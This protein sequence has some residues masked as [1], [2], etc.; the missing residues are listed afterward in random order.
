MNRFAS[1]VLV[2]GAGPSGLS[3]LRAF[4]LAE[5][6][7]SVQIPK[8]KCYEKQ[9]DWGG[10]WNYTWRTGLDQYGEPV[11]GSMYK[12]LWSNAPKECLEFADYSCAQHFE[13]KPMPSYL[14][15]KY[16]R[17]YIVGRAEKSDIRRLIQFNSAVKFVEFTNNVFNVR[18]LDLLTGKSRLEQYDYVIVA[19]SHFSVPNVPHFEGIDSFPGRVIHSHD[20]RDAT[21]FAG[22]KI[23][24]VGA[25]LSAEDVALQTYKF[26]AKSITISYRTKAFGFKWPESIE[27]L[28]LLTRIEGKTVTFS[29]GRQRDFDSIILCT[30]YQHHFPFLADDLRLATRNRMY[31][32]HLYKGIFFQNQPRLMFLGM[33]KFYYILPYFDSQAYYARDVILGR[34]ALPGTEDRLSDMKSWQTRE[35]EIRHPEDGID[36]QAAYAADLL[37]VTDYSKVDLEARTAMFKLGQQHKRDCIVSYR[38]QGFTSTCTGTKAT[39]HHTLWINNKQE[40]LN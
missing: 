13:N 31:P 17:D 3:Q 16:F 34:I 12:H 14:P 5:S 37:A 21:H 27:E 35:E 30:G 4:A 26:G 2:I 18:V 39:T 7:A 6:A 33:Q 23:L 36:F 10:M 38:D 29:D 8:V 24:I 20:L 25:G 15:R 1:R 32:D 28:P 11:H 19:V 40:E 9:S 22:Q